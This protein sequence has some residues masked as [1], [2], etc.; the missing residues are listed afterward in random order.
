MTATKGKEV[1]RAHLG[2]LD[3]LGEL[4]DGLRKEALVFD[5]VAPDGGVVDLAEDVV[6]AAFEG[7]CAERLGSAGEVWMGC[8]GW[9]ALLG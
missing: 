7:H 1:W 5:D 3:A 9:D 4:V 2:R 6:R 8:S